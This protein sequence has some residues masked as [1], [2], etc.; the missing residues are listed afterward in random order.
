MTRFARD[1][2]LSTAAGIVSARIR[3]LPEFRNARELVLESAERRIFDYDRAGPSVAV[4]RRMGGFTAIVEHAIAALPDHYRTNK[5]SKMLPR[6]VAD[7]LGF[8]GEVAA[9]R[10]ELQRRVAR[11]VHN[12]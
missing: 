12:P 10:S 7:E 1:N 11:R 8:G 4:L 3:A 6:S 9:M 5:G 2:S